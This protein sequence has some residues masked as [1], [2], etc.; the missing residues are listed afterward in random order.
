MYKNIVP[1]LVSF[2]TELNE[3]K[4]FV[5]CQ[6]FNFFK[7]TELKNRF[8]YKIV[9]TDDIEV[10]VDYDFRSEYCVRKDNNLYY[11]RS[12]FFWHPVLKY[13]FANRIFYFNRAYYLLPFKLGGIFTI[14]EHISNLIELDLFL[15]SHVILRG[16]AARVNNKN[17]GITAPGFNG[18]TT[19]LKKL[20]RAGAG[21]IAEDYLIL[22]LA[23]NKVYPTCPLTKENFWRRR[24]ID[25]ELR[26][27]L[28]IENILESPEHLDRLYL[29]QNSQNPNHRAKGK[30]FI[31]FLLL[32]SLYFLDNFF[33][34]S[35]IYDQKL[36]S[37]VFNRINEL[38]NLGMPYEY[39]EI[40]QYDFNFLN[41]ALPRK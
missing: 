34:R 40:K 2:D 25:S 23:E 12:I 20:L 13:D 4:G 39:V 36:T 9:L 22:N 21:Y 1:G 30:E 18:K 41:Y 15:N 5:M 7:G 6:D 10:P 16:I 24:E 29:V 37:A 26:G 3:V 19:L 31:D 14:G 35:Y 8:H 17:V 28:S 27:L 38:R 33:V 11:D 32:N